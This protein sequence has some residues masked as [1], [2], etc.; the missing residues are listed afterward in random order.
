MPS[1]AW[2]VRQWL[3]DR[4]SAAAERFADG[5]PADAPRTTSGATAASTS[6]TST[7]SRRRPRPTDRGARRP[8]PGQGPARRA[9]PTP[10]ALGDLPEDGDALVWL[11]PRP[12]RRPRRRST[13]RPASRCAEPIVVRHQGAAD[14]TAVGRRGSSCGPAPT[15]RC[16]S[17]RSSRA[18]AT[19]SSCPATEITVGRGRPGR[20]RRRCSMLD[21]A[22]L[23]GRH[24]RHRARR[25]QA[26]VTAGLAGFG[27]DYARLRTDCRLVGRGATGD[28]LAA[29]FGDGDQTLDFRTFQDHVAPDTTSNLLFKGAVE[30]PVPLRLHRPHPGGKEA[31]GHQRLP[32]QPQHQAVRRRLGRVGAQPR[33]REQRRALQPRLGGRARSTRSSA[34][35]SR[36]AASRPRWPS[37]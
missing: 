19:A 32:D 10:T 27:G 1:P 6:S 3:V 37:G 23:V 31:R 24:A 34:S 18:A 28:L 20:L 29:Y 15:A 14:G 22:T 2:R 25:Q 7:G 17:S 11:A 16:T 35:T 5:D 12:G 21:Q 36:A 4:R 13:C 8:R 26:T 30:R 9:T 33:D